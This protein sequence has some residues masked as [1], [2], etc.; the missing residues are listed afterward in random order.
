MEIDWHSM[1]T[2]PRKPQYKFTKLVTKA[3]TGLHK[4]K[5]ETLGPLLFL[6][7]EPYGRMSYRSLPYVKELSYMVVVPQ[8]LEFL[9]ECKGTTTHTRPSIER[10]VE[11]VS[12]YQ[13]TLVA[14]N[15][16]AYDFPIIVAHATHYGLLDSFTHVR[17]ADSLPSAKRTKG[18][19]RPYTNSSLYTQVTG[20]QPVGQLHTSM[21][22]VQ[23]LCTW[24]LQSQL[25]L[26]WYTLNSLVLYQQRSQLESVSRR[27]VST[28]GTTQP[29]LDRTQRWTATADQP[30]REGDAQAPQG[31]TAAADATIEG[32]AARMDLGIA[33]AVLVEASTDRPED[34]PATLRCADADRHLDG[35]PRGRTV[36]R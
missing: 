15:G 30:T 2:A 17:F 23:I 16:L 13:P 19:R 33:D 21:V 27:T 22:D 10:V 5:I 11:L 12:K 6:D 3:P 24:C 36:A 32:A 29:L 28:H 31:Q 8:G 25:T 26:C 35:A 20:H 9:V 1:K 14:H 18:L 7:L 4:S 34:D